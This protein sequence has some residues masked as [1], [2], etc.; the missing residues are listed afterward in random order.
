M[1][2][3]Q[4]SL[5][6]TIERQVSLC[7]FTC[8]RLFVTFWV[9]PA[10]VFTCNSP[11]LF[12]SFLFLSSSQAKPEP[13]HWNNPE[14]RILLSFSG[15]IGLCLAAMVRQHGWQLPAHAFQVFIHL[16]PSLLES[17]FLGFFCLLLNFWFGYVQIWIYLEKVKN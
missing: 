3:S 11:I 14:N 15:F 1:K 4:W 6:I 10:T 12:S 8:Q 7:L 9:S 17:Q 2:L 16:F 5:S 13:T